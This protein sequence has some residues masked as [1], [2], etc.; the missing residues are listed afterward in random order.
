MQ[1]DTPSIHPFI[2]IQVLMSQYLLKT[3]FPKLSF[4]VSHFFVKGNTVK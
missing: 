3:K 1:E 4:N 2:K